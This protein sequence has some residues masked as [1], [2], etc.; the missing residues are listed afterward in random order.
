MPMGMGAFAGRVVATAVVATDGTGDFTDIQAA[1]DSLPAGGGVVYIKEGT[2]T[3]TSTINITVANVAL[4]GAGK[5]TKITTT[6]NDQMIRPTT[7]DDCLIQSLYLLGNDTGSDQNGIWINNS[8]N[9]TIRNCWIEN[10]GGDGIITA[11]GSN[12]T[13]IVN[14]FIT[15]SSEHG[16]NLTGV[17]NII[18]SNVILSNGFS[19]I[20]FNAADESIANGNTIRDNTR[21]G[22]R[23]SNADDNV[24]SGNFIDDN[25]TSIGHDGIQ[26]DDSDYNVISGNRVK[27]NFDDEIELI[28]DSTG[29]VVVGNVVNGT[30]DGIIDNGTSTQIGHNVS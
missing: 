20:Y 15:S 5:A 6:M 13:I 21:H 9:N 3:I 16:I 14:N 26:L 29:N 27:D 11:N 22:I 17:K 19:G 30:G 28:A 8:D 2:Y 10:T 12:N 4:I 7:A 25:G 24:I 1:I 23:M 18:Q